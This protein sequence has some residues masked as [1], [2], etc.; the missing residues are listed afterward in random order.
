M[1]RSNSAYCS[2]VS[3]VRLGASGCGLR[4]FVVCAGD[5][6]IA[7]VR[8]ADVMTVSPAFFPDAILPEKRHE[9][10]KI[11]ENT[12]RAGE[13]HAR[14]RTAWPVAAPVYGCGYSAAR[15]CTTTD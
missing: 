3:S 1:M 9:R 15:Q 2:F 12:E 14:R 10:H 13:R 11:R 5:E 7:S 4:S 6:R 8:R